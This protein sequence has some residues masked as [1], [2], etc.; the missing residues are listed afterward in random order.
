VE[1]ETLYSHGSKLPDGSVAI[2]Y[3]I[4]KQIEGTVVVYAAKAENPGKQEYKEFPVLADACAWIFSK[5]IDDF[6]GA[7]PV[8]FYELQELWI[9]ANQDAHNWSLTRRVR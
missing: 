2:G 9:K 7:I 6:G 8:F 4:T 5:M 3:S 1:S